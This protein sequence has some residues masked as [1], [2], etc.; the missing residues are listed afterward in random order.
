MI[1]YFLNYLKIRLFQQI[2]MIHYF[3]NYL[4]IR[5]YQHYLMYLMILM[6]RMNHEC[7]L[8]RMSH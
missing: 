7:H 1:H 4:K 2:L 6:Y 3:L 8:S 5:L